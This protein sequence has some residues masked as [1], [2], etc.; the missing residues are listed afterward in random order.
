MRL[1][2]KRNLDNSW[3]AVPCCLKICIG[4]RL[5]IHLSA[6]IG[7]ILLSIMASHPTYAA[8]ITLNL[9]TTYAVAKG[10]TS[11]HV[12]GGMGIT[13][14][15]G[16]AITRALSVGLE[17]GE[18]WLFTSGA[19]AN[20]IGNQQLSIPVWSMSCQ[21]RFAIGLSNSW[22]FFVSGGYGYYWLKDEFIDRLTGR[23][24]VNAGAGI[25]FALSET[26]S[27]Y[28][29]FRVHRLLKASQ[30]ITLVPVAFGVRF[31]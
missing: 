20:K 15:A 24:G 5:Q 19:A 6:C 8:D 31:H 14:G 25:S 28:F 22:R 10:V 17:G 7:L 23:Q 13:G 3:Y 9:G 27:L 2:Y 1:F 29:D 18:S 12:D 4:Y 21:P 30:Q 26:T 16:I 11:S